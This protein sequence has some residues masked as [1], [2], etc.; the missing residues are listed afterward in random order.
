M[1]CSFC[2]T[3]TSDIP[4]FN[5]NIIRSDFFYAAHKLPGLP[6][7]RLPSAMQTIALLFVL[8]VYSVSASTLLFNPSHAFDEQDVASEA[9]K[10]CCIP[11]QVETILVTVGP[12]DHDRHHDDDQ[13]IE[14]SEDV[15]A[16]IGDVDRRRLVDMV[17]LAFAACLDFR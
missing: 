3:D 4:R 5:N 14:L 12:A 7:R 16:I 17:S 8:A 13:D 9:G 1:F 11:K 6:F 2:I 15:K 10:P